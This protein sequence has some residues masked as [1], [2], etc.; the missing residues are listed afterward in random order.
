LGL[1]YAGVGGVGESKAERFPE[2]QERHVG[3]EGC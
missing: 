3:A 1:V 2:L